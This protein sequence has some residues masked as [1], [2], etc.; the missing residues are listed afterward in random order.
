MKN[1]QIIFLF[2][3]TTILINSCVEPFES[4]TQNFEDTLI[5]EAT[6][7]NDIDFQEVN[8]SRTY[9]LEDEDRKYESNANV[10]V[11]DDLL[12]EYQFQESSTGKYISAIKFGAVSDRE[13]QL[14]IVTSGGKK[15]E[16]IPTKLT[17]ISTNFNIRAEKNTNEEG[18]EGIIILANSIDPSG[19]SKY[20]RFT[21]EETYKIIAP[22]WS[23][24]DAFGV[25]Y[26]PTTTPTMSYPFY[27]EVY[28]LPRTKEEKTCY[29]TN[30]SNVILQEETNK[31]IEDRVTDF[32]ILFISKEEF[33]ITH[34]Y[35]ILVNQR[36][37]S[38]KAYSFYTTLNKLSG[39][40]SIF[41]QNQPGFIN[42][43]LYS[44]DNPEERVLGFFEV[45]SSLSERLFFNF[46]D[47]FPNEP[48]PEYITDCDVITP[49]LDDRSLFG[50]PE[51][52][53]LI[54]LL[55]FQGFK[56][57]DFNPPLRIP[58]NNPYK[59]VKKECGDCTN[60]GSNVKPSFWID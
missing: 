42:G 24:T 29:G 59:I 36:V 9:R 41:S 44:V 6:L 23:P 40:G 47:F 2:I 10:K 19:N 20:Y 48:K 45:S 53:P 5:V 33:K 57:V 13:Y 1:K 34:R 4:A 14:K 55:F 11:V 51:F 49:D 18:D 21:Y 15:Y 58:H 7:T 50:N 43:N 46:E 52:S 25:S 30:Y 12:N 26:V 3:L 39:Q 60:L 38:F 17:S 22:F 54:Q 35:S 8:L 32:P 27:H 28:T 31:F 56:F 16:S 37:Q